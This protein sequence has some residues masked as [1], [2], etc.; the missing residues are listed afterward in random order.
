D[1]CL[2]AC[3]PQPRVDI[4]LLPAK[5]GPCR[6]RFSKF[7]YNSTSEMCE[8]FIYGGCQGNENRFETR[9]ECEVRCKDASVN[10]CLL[11]KETGPCEA[12]IRKFYYNAN[13]EQCEEFIYGGCQGNDNRFDTQREC[14]NACKGTTTPQP[15]V[16]ICML[17]SK[18][19]PCRASFP[20]FFYNSTSEMC[21]DFIYGG[22]QGNE[23]RFETRQECEKK[24]SN[25]PPT[26][27]PIDTCLQPSKT[28]PC[29]ALF[30]KFYYNASTGTC[31]EFI[32]GGCQG[33]DNRFE[34]QQECENACYGTT[35][36]Q[37]PVDT[38]LLPP[39]TGPCRASFP[40]F[41]YNS[42]S[43]MC[44]DFIYGGCQ[45]NDNRFETRQECEVR[46]KDS[47]VNICLLPK[48]TG[49]CEALIRKF[50]YN[51]NTEKCEEFIY[52]G[53]QGN[54]NRF[55]TQRECENACKG[56]TTP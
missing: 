15:R 43:E 41:F 12:L 44:E 23:N 34:T 28:G 17:P 16:D 30:R 56:T 49:P 1:E 31:E 10:I 38:C 27:S 24:C 2:R 55:D 4:C 6:A 7:F 39:E 9:Q 3:T 5:T 21:E 48:E 35:T 46:C 33:N 53:C 25:A 14:E 26:K 18:T 36:P 42:T 47:S 40:K 20:K 13:T 54:D 50:Y 19:G 52:G 37:P 11:P 29:L 22:C 8:S 45:G 32:Y 51:A